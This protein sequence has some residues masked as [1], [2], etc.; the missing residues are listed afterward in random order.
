MGSIGTCRELSH[1]SHQC[2]CIRRSFSL[3]A[4]YK[5]FYKFLVSTLYDKKMSAVAQSRGRLLISAW[6]MPQGTEGWMGR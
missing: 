2:F 1:Q 6:G 4:M 5:Y 3:S